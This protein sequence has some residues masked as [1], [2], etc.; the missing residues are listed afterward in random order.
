[1]E[2]QAHLVEQLRQYHTNEEK[3]EFLNKIAA[4]V[5][6]KREEMMGSEVAR[7]ME[8]YVT[9]QVTDNLWMDHLD[10]IDN[11]RE[12]V[13]L[14]GYAQKDP[15]VEYKNEAYKMFEQL[16]WNMEDQIV[17]RIYKIQVQNQEGHEGHN[18]GPIGPVSVDLSA[19]VANTPES[20]VSEDVIQK[21]AAKARSVKAKDSSTGIGATPTSNK[22]PGRNDPCWCGSGKKYKKCHFPN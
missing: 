20:E 2:S 3:I 11:L 17:H 1:M 21:K 5:Y 18:H 12:G 7:T 9:L 14:R 6:K 8:K 15:L 10:A 13:R 19:A 22:K 16:I 4:D